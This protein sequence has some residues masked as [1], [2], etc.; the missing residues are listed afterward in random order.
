MIDI[1]SSPSDRKHPLLTTKHHLKKQQACV[2][3]SIQFKVSSFSSGPR[4]H[5]ENRQRNRCL[6]S[7]KC[8]WLAQ[9]T[10]HCC[11][12]VLS[13]IPSFAAWR[14]EKS[15][16]AITSVHN[17]ILLPPEIC[18]MAASFIFWKP[19]RVLCT[20]L[21]SNLTVCNFWKLLGIYFCHS[22]P[23]ASG[24]NTIFLFCPLPASVGFVPLVH[25][26]NNSVPALKN[27]LK[28]C[29][30]AQVCVCKVLFCLDL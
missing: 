7:L 18:F 30:F 19:C 12:Q 2:L 27:A 9:L 8:S 13:L 23:H 11:I 16:C 21:K 4:L 1:L 6:I 25:V 15:S 3:F 22:S 17:I 28:I 20:A 14:W 29:L 26:W 5:T 24:E 10:P